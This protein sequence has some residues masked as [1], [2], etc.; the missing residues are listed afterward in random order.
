MLQAAQ[1]G[2]DTLVHQLFQSLPRVSVEYNRAMYL[3]PESWLPDLLHYAPKT[4]RLFDSTTHASVV[5]RVSAIRVS[6]ILQNFQNNQ[7][8]DCLEPRITL[9]KQAGQPWVI[10]AQPNGS[11]FK[12]KQPWQ[13]LAK[14]LQSS[15]PSRQTVRRTLSLF[16]SFDTLPDNH[17]LGAEIRSSRGLFQGKVYC[18]QAHLKREC[19]VPYYRLGISTEERTVSQKRQ[20]RWMLRNRRYRQPHVERYAGVSRKRP[21]PPLASIKQ[22]CKYRR[23]G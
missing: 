2:H 11:T 4:L 8:N 9:A 16:L 21:G 3:Y 14:V 23:C 5:A 17:P 13:T 20:S 7:W 22:Q 15:P 18:G 10:L 1:D 19:V 12:N 6:L